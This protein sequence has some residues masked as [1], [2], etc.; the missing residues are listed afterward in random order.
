MELALIFIFALIAWYASGILGSRLVVIDI[1]ER[2]G[3][4]FSEIWKRDRWA[5]R[6]VSLGGLIL[7]FIAL[8]LYFFGPKEYP[9]EP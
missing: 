4:T 1:A 2:E 6:I 5:V 8:V 9:Y 3:K 7:L